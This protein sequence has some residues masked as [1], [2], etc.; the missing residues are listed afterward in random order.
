MKLLCQVVQKLLPEQTETQTDTQTDTE[1][2]RQTE[3]QTDMTKNITYPHTQVV[4]S[5]ELTNINVLDF[6]HKT[7]ILI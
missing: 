3:R 1:T 2:D 4:I 7:K 5:L 6:I